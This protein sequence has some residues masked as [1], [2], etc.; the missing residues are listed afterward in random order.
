MAGGIGTAEI[1]TSYNYPLKTIMNLIP[2][3]NSL[4]PRRYKVGIQ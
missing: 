2:T 4:V 1:R 3:R